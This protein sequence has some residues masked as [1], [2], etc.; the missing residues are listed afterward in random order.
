MASGD[1]CPYVEQLHIGMTGLHVAAYQLMLHR[2]NP[3]VRPYGAAPDEQHGYFGEPMR[4][5]VKV[6]QRLWS[7][8]HPKQ[9]PIPQT[10]YIGPITHAALAR[11]ADSRACALLKQQ[12]KLMHPKTTGRNRV[13]EAAR[14]ALGEKGRMIYSGPH[15]KTIARRW[16]GIQDRLMP[17]K[18]PKY[19]DC[20]SLLTWCLWTA[21]NQG[22]KDPSPQSGKPAWSWGTT[23]SMIP[24]GQRRKLSEVEAGD[25]IFYGEG[26]SPSHVA[27]VV[28]RMGGIPWVI[29]FGQQGGP[30]YEAYNYRHDF[31]G[32]RSYFTA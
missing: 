14:H 21:R 19:A 22:A 9:K 13:A 10:G 6:F 7:E 11:S 5:Q 31:F 3:H 27:I 1:R 25:L 20:S 8:A 28:D 15:T 23:F 16:Q 24:H 32:V 4:A 12:Y 26:S 18:V 17:P 30:F 29:S 2:W